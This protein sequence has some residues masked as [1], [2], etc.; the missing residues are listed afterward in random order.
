MIT[1]LT[2]TRGSYYLAKSAAT[3]TLSNGT[4]VTSGHQYLMDVTAYQ[5]LSTS[6]TGTYFTSITP[7]SWNQVQGASVQALLTGGGPWPPAASSDL[8]R[9]GIYVPTG[10]GSNWQAARANAKAASG[11]ARVAFVGSSS[12]QGLYASNLVSTSLFGR[13]ATGLQ[14]LYND[15]GSGFFSVS[16]S[17][18]WQGASSSSTAWAATAGNFAS[19]S[20]TWSVGNNYG[21]GGT[22]LFTSTN[23]NTITF[24]NVRGTSIRVYTIGGGGRVNW[25]YTIDGGAAV[26]VSDSGLSTGTV[27]VTNIT[28]LSAGN[29][30]IVIAHN[31][32]NGNF[33]SVCGVTGENA[34][35][36]VCN[37]F[38]QSGAG[39][40]LF[41]DATLAIGPG[42]WSGGPDYTADLIVYGLGA[43]DVLSGLSG[44]SW[45][46]NV[47]KYL[48]NARDG[49]L[50]AGGTASSN[51]DI[52]ILMQHIG[53]YD[54][55]NLRWQDY[56]QRA[57]GLADSFNA[58]LVSLWPMGH[59]SW[60]Y[61]NSLGYWGNSA[62]V[63]A[64]GTDT[65]H[66]SDAGHQFAATQLLSVL[67][68]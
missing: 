55:T 31:G 53:N 12:V 20:G 57:R 42:Q 54:T 35:G 6:D 24:A 47:R 45:A 19:T 30:T 13:T 23:G 52:L 66:M 21:P 29:H 68:S 56:V 49:S 1:D 59:N 3:G 62:S 22:Y 50:Y 25:T 64:A 15:G 2:P 58:A 46:A 27:Q 67:T 5:A 39:S 28:G 61:F 11:L 48:V 36:V 16:R 33:L 26:P 63:G 38:A 10:W 41:S 4:S 34:S 37:N 9:T 43:N 7:V 40:A 32:T 17:T 60:N 18:V 14:A 65:I 51:V 44:D 8:R